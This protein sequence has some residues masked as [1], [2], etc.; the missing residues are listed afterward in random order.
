[1]NNNKKNTDVNSLIKSK[2]LYVHKHFF[3]DTSVKV[4]ISNNYHYKSTV[5][6]KN[7]TLDSISLLSSQVTVCVCVHC[8]VK[9]KRE[10]VKGI[11]GRQIATVLFVLSNAHVSQT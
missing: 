1:M 10:T 4:R 9:R 8:R 11:G 3:F 5:C 2:N 6:E 7:S